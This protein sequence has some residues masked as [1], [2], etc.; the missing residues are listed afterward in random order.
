MS[1]DDNQDAGERLLDGIDL[2]A[3]RVPPP[4]AVHR[5]SLLVRA[6]TPATA[7]AKRPR[8]AWIVAAILITNALVAA[9]IVIVIGRQT[10][11]RT[12]VI[13]APGG[14]PADPHVRDMLQRL[15][16]RAAEIRELQAL[17]TDLSA[18]VEQCEQKEHTVP[19]SRPPSPP[20]KVGPLPLDPYAAPL[21]GLGCDEVGCV[22]GNY[23]EACCAKYKKPP[24]PAPTNP[25]PET[26][27][28]TAISNT[29][30]V[31]K[32]RIEACRDNVAISGK[33]KVHVLV[34]ASGQVTNVTVEATPDAQLGA[35]VAVV[36]QRAAFPK[37]QAGGSFSY[38]FIF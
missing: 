15:D 6:L 14:G 10:T 8:L 33:V 31:L 26:L 18:K 35:C 13:Q 27:D 29:I 34:A 19:R 24:V 23:S 12:V 2:H 4:S 17:I 20:L 5:P 37:T 21:T 9:L 7:P 30:S 32:P 1:H 22:L 28:R 38:P 3:W 36:L 25:L 11:E 16:Q